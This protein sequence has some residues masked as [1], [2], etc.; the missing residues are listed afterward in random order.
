MTLC[1]QAVSALLGARYSTI[2]SPSLRLRIIVPD[3]L[4]CFGKI[5]RTV[6]M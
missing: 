6:N 4:L 3:Y 5:V 2:I 1:M